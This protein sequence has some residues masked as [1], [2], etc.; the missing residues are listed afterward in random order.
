[1]AEEVLTQEMLKVANKKL[2]DGLVSDDPAQRKQAEVIA[3]NYIRTTLREDSFV[4]RIIPV[5]T[6][7]AAD[8]DRQYDTDKPTVLIDKEPNSPGAVSVPFGTLPQ[9]FTLRGNKVKVNFD[10]VLTPKMSKDVNELL[11]YEMDIRQIVADNMAKDLSTEKDGKFMQAV[12]W[13]VGT[14]GVT[15]SLTGIIQNQQISGGIAR[16]TIAE[17]KKI[18][19][20][21]P[22]RLRPATMLMNQA[23]AC[24]FEKW[25]R[26]EVG[27]DR[28]QEILEKGW[29]EKELSGMNQL[30]T[31][32]RE[33][34]PDNVIYWFCA[35]EFLG[36]N[37]LLDDVTF[38]VKREAFMLEMFSYFSPG[39]T[40][41]HVAGIIKTTFV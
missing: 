31:I 41:G 18:M 23:T 4:D 25:D 34:V 29:V 17:A 19:M 13:I 40:I 7:T 33:L 35:P 11:T 21:T 5:R 6:I 14:L 8:L 10:R 22:Y 30:I 1:M 26:N 9:G 38:S 27:G 37:L 15:N 36:V 28:A 20:T 39:M 24:E 2:I 16:D 32:K 3:G 12:N